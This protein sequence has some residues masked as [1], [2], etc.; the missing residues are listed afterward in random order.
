MTQPPGRPAKKASR[1][2]PTSS[3]GGCRSSPSCCRGPAGRLG[4]EIR[5]R[6]EGYA[7]MSDDAF[8][9]RFYEDRAELAGSGHRHR[10]RHRGRGRHR[11]LLPAGVGLLPAGHRAHPRRACGAG[12]LPV[13]ARA[14]LRLQRAAA[15]GPAQPHPRPPGAA[16]PRGRHPGERA[17]RAR[18]APRGGRPAQAAAGGRDRQDRDVRLL[19]HRPRRGARAHGRPLRPAAGRRRVVSHRLLSPA[20]GDPHLPPVAAAL[21]G[22]LRH[23][24][25][26]RLLAPRRLCDRRLPR[27]ARLAAR[28]TGGQ[29]HRPRDGRHGVVGRGALLALRHD[30][31]GDRR[32]R[33]R[34]RHRLYSTSY[35]SPQ[36][37]VAWVLSMGAAA[38]LLEPQ[39]LRHE[40]RAR[41]LRLAGRLG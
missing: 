4:G 31:A 20:P 39:E 24:R 37:L 3:S 15:A 19:L 1:R 25:S 18:G 12:R 32:R 14:P 13:R 23:P 10:R 36:Q 27:P 17:A 22:D 28:R 21:A 29:R 41:L 16:L 9:R 35:N 40:L 2:T 7:L 11:A 8:K 26:P 5:Q 30:R 33:A 38:E 6:V 34:P